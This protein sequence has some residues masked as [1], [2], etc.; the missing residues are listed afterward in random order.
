MSIIDKALEANR[1]YRLPKMSPCA[2]SFLTSTLADFAKSRY[3][4]T[5]A[6]RD[7]RF[8]PRTNHVSRRLVR[9]VSF[10]GRELWITMRQSGNLNI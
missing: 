8:C 5:S 1:N 6:P 7:E 2:A 4:K 10:M 3:S 9:C